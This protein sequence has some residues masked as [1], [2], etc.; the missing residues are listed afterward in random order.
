M[1]AKGK[2]ELQQELNRQGFALR[3]VGQWP[4]RLTYYKAT[5]E[6]MPNLPA[7]PFSMSRYLKRGFTLVPPVVTQPDISKH[8]LCEECGFEAKSQSGLYVHQL[9]HSKKGDAK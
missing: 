6:P 3:P 2:R 9:K 1:D 7:D 4:T 8:W 5:G